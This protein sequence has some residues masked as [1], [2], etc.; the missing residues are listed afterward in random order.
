MDLVIY[1]S[2][3]V[4]LSCA[5]FIAENRYSAVCAFVLYVFWSVC[6]FVCVLLCC[7]VP[8]VGDNLWCY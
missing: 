2:R 1:I 8:V 7:A 6:L 4:L 3:L 5:H